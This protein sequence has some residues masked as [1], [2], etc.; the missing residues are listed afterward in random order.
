MVLK[1]RAKVPWLHTTPRK[2][3]V[4]LGSTWPATQNHTEALLPEIARL[5][6][7][8]HT[9]THTRP[10]VRMEPQG[11]RRDARGLCDSDGVTAILSHTLT[12]GFAALD[13]TTVTSNRTRQHMR[14]HGCR[15]SH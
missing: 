13:T 12:L 1:N 5:H 8:A 3:T 11:G 7:A 9:H 4:V 15:P 2:H 14:A 6:T 10:A